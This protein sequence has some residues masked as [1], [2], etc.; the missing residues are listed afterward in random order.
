MKSTSRKIVLTRAVAE[1]QHHFLF[2]SFLVLP[3]HFGPYPQIFAKTINTSIFMTR[4]FGIRDSN[5]M[6]GCIFRLTCS[7]RELTED[8]VLTSA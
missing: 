1:R 4:C 7:H 6:Q 5:C 2:Y 3:S 8:H